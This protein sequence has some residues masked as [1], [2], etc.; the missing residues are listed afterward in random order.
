M[1]PKQLEDD[2]NVVESGINYI[3]IGLQD[4]AYKAGVIDGARG[5]SSDEVL[6][7]KYDEQRL[8][9]RKAC[10]FIYDVLG[11][12]GKRGRP[13]D[14]IDKTAWHRIIQLIAEAEELEAKE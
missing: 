1:V 9:W 14:L 4:R 12:G 3:L 6:R 2:F 5:D 7:A 13:M 11:E 8:A 10:R